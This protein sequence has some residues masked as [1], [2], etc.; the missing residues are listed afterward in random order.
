MNHD[1]EICETTTAVGPGRMAA[2]NGSPVDKRVVSLRKELTA[3]KLDA[4][5]IPTSD[6]HMV[7]AGLPELAGCP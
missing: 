7:R 3:K 6:A 1:A 4:Y 2:A 5:I